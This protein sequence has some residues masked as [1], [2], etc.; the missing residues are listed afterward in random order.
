LTTIL[1]LGYSS[2][3]SYNLPAS[4]VMTIAPRFTYTFSRNI[5]GSLSMN[6]KRSAGGRFGY[7]NH[8]VSLHATAEFKF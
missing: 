8:E 7:I 4:T 5:S 3:E 1:N 6:Y 2:T